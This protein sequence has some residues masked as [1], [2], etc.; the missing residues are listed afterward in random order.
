MFNPLVT[1]KSVNKLYSKEDTNIYSSR[2]YQDLSSGFAFKLGEKNKKRE[3]FSFSPNGCL[4]EKLLSR[5]GLFDCYY[6]LENTIEEIAYSMLKYGIAYLYID[7]QYE[8]SDTAVVANTTEPKEIF[9]IKI[10]EI[11]GVIKGRSKDKTVMYIKNFSGNILKKELLTNRIIEFNTRDLGYRQNYFSNIIKQIGK[12]DPLT[13]TDLITE[14]PKGY[15]FN[16]HVKASRIKFLK[17]IRHIGWTFGT[18]EMSDS[19]I[20]YKELMEQKFMLQLLKYILDKIN[21]SLALFLN[22]EAAGSI[23]ATVREIDYDEIWKKFSVGEITL[24]E[25]SNLLYQSN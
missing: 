12:Y 24:T 16:L 19:Y 17:R 21:V 6:R 2:F 11:R 1:A 10:G 22:T 15:D 18:E 25:L 20:L 5:N 4:I 7:P 13:S 8:D 23:T 3:F 9:A 14:N